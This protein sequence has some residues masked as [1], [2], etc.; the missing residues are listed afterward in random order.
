[1]GCSGQMCDIPPQLICIRL[2]LAEGSRGEICKPTLDDR[3]INYQLLQNPEARL[4]L[5]TLVEKGVICLLS[6]AGV[7]RHDAELK[8]Y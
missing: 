8:D 6:S 4:N 5:L 2:R 7:V 1:M 3:N